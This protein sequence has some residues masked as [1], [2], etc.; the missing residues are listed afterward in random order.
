MRSGLSHGSVVERV[1]QGYFCGSRRGRG[2]S[3]GTRR[4]HPAGQARARDRLQAS[5]T[6]SCPFREMAPGRSPTTGASRTAR[7]PDPAP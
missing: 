4:W 6:E 1:A 7:S 2:W 5:A 3:E